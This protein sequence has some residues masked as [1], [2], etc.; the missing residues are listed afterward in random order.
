L[1]KHVDYS[2]RLFATGGTDGTPGNAGL[3]QHGFNN[4]DAGNHYRRL[5]SPSNSDR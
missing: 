5:N 2:G 1:A 4:C 3:C